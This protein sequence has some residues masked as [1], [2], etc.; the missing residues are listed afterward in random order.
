MKNKKKIVRLS[1][2]KF[3]YSNKN[4]KLINK[5]IQADLKLEQ[6][7]KNLVL[8]TNLL[9]DYPDGIVMASILVIKYRDTIHVLMDGYDPQYK[10]F[11]A[12]HLLIW[13]LMEKYSKLGYKKFNLGG[14]TNFNIE[15]NKYQGLNQF[16]L[17]F[18]AK[19]YEYIGDL[20]LITNNTLY[21]M[22]RNSAPI[23]NIFKKY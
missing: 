13:K 8:A 10:N 17:N 12:K 11:N 7:K 23:R 9:R 19:A 15:N 16:K 6:C 1:I 3:N 14:I 20:E 22:Y 2:N 21:F 18:G 5:K 4:N